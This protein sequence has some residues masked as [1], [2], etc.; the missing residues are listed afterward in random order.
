MRN[1]K[2]A[3]IINRTHKA[4]II[5]LS[6]FLLLAILSFPL[7]MYLFFFCPFS[8]FVPPLSAC[9]LFQ[10]CQHFFPLQPVLQ[11]GMFIPDSGSENFTSRIPWFEFFPSR[12][13]TKIEVFLTQKALG[14]MIWVVHP[15]SG[16]WHF[17]HPGS[18]IQESKRNP[19][20]RIPYSNSPHCLQ[21]FFFPCGF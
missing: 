6:L 20:S 13:R 5:Y 3:Y 7:F 18:R 4:I 17:I 14:N 2:C 15:G 10:S 8:L 9:I 11:I 16:S 21:P 12:I 19:G 1:V